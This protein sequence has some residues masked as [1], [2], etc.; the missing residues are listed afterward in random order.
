MSMEFFAWKY[1]DK[2]FGRMPR[3]KFMH[4]QNLSFIPY[5]TIVD[6][7]VII[8]Y[9]QPNLTPRNAVPSGKSRK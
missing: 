5:G 7:Y 9:S 1:I 3:N 4:A 6:Y 8:I 2:F